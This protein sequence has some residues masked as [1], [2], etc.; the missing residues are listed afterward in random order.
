M[1]FLEKL[2]FLKNL[3]YNLKNRKERKEDS[4]DLWVTGTFHITVKM[5]YSKFKLVFLNILFIFNL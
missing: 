5:E 1:C 3:N 2:H 4:V